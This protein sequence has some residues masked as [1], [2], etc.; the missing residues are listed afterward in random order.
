MSH[1]ANDHP[2]I[3]CSIHYVPYLPMEQVSGC[4]PKTAQSSVQ[5]ITDILHRSTAYSITGALLTSQVSSGVY[6]VGKVNQ[7]SITV[8]C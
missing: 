6:S 1:P 2:P 5:Y 4:V 8:L 3:R 7:T